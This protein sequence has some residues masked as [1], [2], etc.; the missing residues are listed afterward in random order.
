MAKNTRVEPVEPTDP[1]NRSRLRM[2]GLIAGGVLALGATFAAGAAI[3]NGFDGHR[4]GDFAAGQ[5]SGDG[6]RGPGHSEHDKGDHDGDREMGHGPH[7]DRDGMHG[8]GRG[9]LNGDRDGMHGPGSS[10]PDNTAPAP[11]VTP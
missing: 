4:G 10:K 6:E 7:G 8:P 2:A 1:P 3:G 5:Q 11:E 9:G